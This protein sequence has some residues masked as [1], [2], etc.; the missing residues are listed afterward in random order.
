MDVARLSELQDL[1]DKYNAANAAGQVSALNEIIAFVYDDYRQVMIA[2]H[3]RMDLVVG[4][5]LMTGSAVVRNKD[6]AQSEQGATE[7]IKIELP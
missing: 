1:L 2:A 4:S 5:L 6:K 7:L 3:K